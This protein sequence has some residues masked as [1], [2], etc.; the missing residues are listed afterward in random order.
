MSQ[1]AVTPGAVATQA[2]QAACV[3]LILGVVAATGPVQASD[4]GQLL[5]SGDWLL[6]YERKA[7]VKM[8]LYNK[9]DLGSRH[10]CIGKEP[11]RM[12]LDWLKDKRCTITEDRL[13]GKVWHLAGSCQVKWSDKPVPVNVDIALAD[14][15][16]FVMDTRTPSGAFLDFKEHTVA[17]YLGKTCAA[18]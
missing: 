10:A 7:A 17:T 6:S 8:L 2:R 3:A 12:V 18:D 4:L 5:P 1:E 15:K 9:S 13:Q 11:R 16:S 14:G